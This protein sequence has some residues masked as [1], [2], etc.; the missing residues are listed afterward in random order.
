MQRC[1]ERERERES[2]KEGVKLSSLLNTENNLLQYLWLSL[3]AVLFSIALTAICLTV[4][5]HT[6]RPDADR[7]KVGQ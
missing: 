6:A 5:F 1:R 4:Q 3:H 2:K 7:R